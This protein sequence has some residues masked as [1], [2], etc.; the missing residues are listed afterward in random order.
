MDEDDVIDL[1][2][3]SQSQDFDEPALSDED[4]VIEIGGGD[5]DDDELNEIEVVGAPGRTR[6]KS[7]SGRRKG[8]RGRGDSC[9]HVISN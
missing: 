7:A 8:G 1:C 6:L 5:E 9:D 2:S 3:Q 4:D